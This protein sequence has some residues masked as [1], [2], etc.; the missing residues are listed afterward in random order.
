METYLLY[1]LL[2][3]DWFE[4]QEL[5]I[6]YEE[7]QQYK[8]NTISEHLK[9]YG[10]AEYDDCSGN[11]KEINSRLTDAHKSHQL[12]LGFVTALIVLSKMTQAYTLMF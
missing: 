11:V 8:K 7:Y 2:T 6:E 9:N 4:K 3:S 12:S 5:K 1:K 10:I